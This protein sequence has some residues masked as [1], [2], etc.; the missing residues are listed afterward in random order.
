MTVIVAAGIRRCFAI[1]S[2]SPPRTVALHS[3]AFWRAAKIPPL[4]NGI[5]LGAAS[6]SK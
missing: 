5:A 6:Y 1:V 4:D 2:C 3:Y